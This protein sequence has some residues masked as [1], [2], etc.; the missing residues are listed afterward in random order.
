MLNKRLKMRYR[1]VIRSTKYFNRGGPPKRLCA[2]SEPIGTEKTLKFRIAK[3]TLQG[4]YLKVAMHAF[5]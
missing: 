1:R 3:N 4:S 5:K 2:S